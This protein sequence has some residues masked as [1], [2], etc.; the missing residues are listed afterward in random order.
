M[1]ADTGHLQC[2]FCGAYEVDRLYIG[3]LHVDA[4]TCEGCGARWDQDSETGRY[5]GRGGLESV[6]APRRR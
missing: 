6:I 2:P 1:D 5:R 3:S 4:C